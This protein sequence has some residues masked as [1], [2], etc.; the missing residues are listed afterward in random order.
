MLANAYTMEKTNNKDRQ[1]GHT[2][3]IPQLKVIFIFGI[4]ENISQTTSY[5][6]KKIFYWTPFRGLISLSKT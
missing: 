5:V 1:M 3:K 6:N 4:F 2:K